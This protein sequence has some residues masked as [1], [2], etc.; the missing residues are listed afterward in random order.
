MR[1]TLAQIEPITGDLEGNTRRILEVIQQHDA[2]S[3]VIV[4]PEM[5]VT[6]YNCGADFECEEFVQDAWECIEKIIAPA[7]GRSFVLAGAPTFASPMHERNG[8]IRIHNT[9]LLMHEGG[10]NVIFVQ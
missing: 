9:A 10:F 3:D 8:S 1:I 4:F 2:D 5:A 7:V 6:G